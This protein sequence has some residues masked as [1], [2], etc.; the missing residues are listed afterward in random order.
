[1]G[2]YRT[3]TDEQVA[4]ALRRITSPQLRRAFFEGLENP[5]WVKPLARTGTF[6]D[7]PEPKRTDD[8]L[9]R[10]HHWPEIGYLTRVATEV[11]VDVV[12]VL[13]RLHESNNAW[14]KRG[15]FEIGAVVPPEQAA[16]LQPLIKAWLPTGLGWRTDPSHLV[17][18]AVNLLN[19]GQ[20]KVGRWFANVIF[21]PSPGEDDRFRTTVLGDYWYED[22]L[23]RIV[24]A[25]GDEGLPVVLPW[26][27]EHERKAGRFTDDMDVTYFDRESIRHRGDSYDGVTQ[28]LI[29]SVRDLAVQA[30]AA[31]APTAVSLL[32]R[33]RMLVARRI[34]M[35]ALAEYLNDPASESTRGELA[36]IAHKLLFEPT[37]AG[38]S[39]RIEFA[40]LARAVTNATGQPIAQLTEF[41]EQGPRVERDLLRNWLAREGLDETALDEE[42]AD[43]IRRWKHRWLSALGLQTLPQPLRAELADL[44]LQ[45]GVIDDPLRPEPRITSWVGPTSPLDQ[46]EMALMTGDDLIAHLESWH[47]SGSG[48]DPE[49]SH[50]GQGRE[51]SS[52]LATNPNALGDVVGIV[53]R[54]RP[55]YV[56]AI[57]TGWE[58]ALKADLP[59]DWGPVVRTLSEVLSHA[60]ESAIKSEGSSF[61]DD[62]DMRPCKRAAVGLLEEAVKRR[63]GRGVPVETVRALADLL[64]HA[65]DDERAWAEYIAHDGTG[66]MD[67]LT[68]SLNWQWPVRLRGLTHLMAWRS[69]TPWFDAAR[70][71]LERELDREDSWGASRAV[72]GESV[73]RLLDAVPDWTAS[74]APDL[75]GAGHT[76]SVGQQIALTTATAVY[77][78]HRVLYEL[79]APAMVAAINSEEAIT[80]GWHTQTDPLQAIG[81]WAVESIIRGDS[82]IEHPVAQAFFSAAPAEVRGAALGHIGWTFMHAPAVDDPFRDRLASL[83]DERVANVRSHSGSE[84]E[85][86]G[87]HRFV[88]SHKF[89]IEW[90]LPRLR[91]ALELYPALGAERFMIGKEVALAADVD[92]Q[93]A[94]DVLKL[95]LETRDQDGLASYDISRNA[96][97]VVLGRAIASG[98]AEL[99]DEAVRFMNELGEAG[100]LGL[101]A[102]VQA[103]IDGAVTQADVDG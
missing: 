27:N 54:L 93:A 79:L 58:A 40:E 87:F 51:L 55:T 39:C 15:V 99:K 41:I 63:D 12:D 47:A 90:W 56:R 10:D 29:D 25:L 16:R 35:F 52:L 45:Y 18:Y 20:R 85:L 3:P 82:T 81:E 8:G 88:R 64:I 89:P 57:L 61:D 49:P 53:E 34:A 7:P 11:P 102:E 32:V 1:V 68:T 83:W 98:D 36:G 100:H 44:D 76:L 19:G 95:L 84:A 46:N 60:D 43:Y 65:A 71:A 78:Y 92:P 70:R 67:P 48:W 94:L 6:N 37:S 22:E 97:P 77:R 31:N 59:L 103:V 24:A 9:I 30:M 38:E 69:D 80:S 72:M 17:S 13:L 28:A 74:K 2:N 101:A 33:S 62:P 86:N 4:A 91:E 23:P 75:F 42:V 66:G 5:Y 21:R 26:L 73:G 96:V 14:V 50:E